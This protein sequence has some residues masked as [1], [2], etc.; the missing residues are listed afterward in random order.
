MPE[1]NRGTADKDSSTSV[2]EGELWAEPV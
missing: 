2:F 1:H